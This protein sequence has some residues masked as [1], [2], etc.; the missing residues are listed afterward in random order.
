MFPSPVFI[1][2]GGGIFNFLILMVS[3]CNRLIVHLIICAAQ[4]RL[5]SPLSSLLDFKNSSAQALDGNAVNF[6]DHVVQ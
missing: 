2:G 5:L 6:G 3:T 1:G 4:A